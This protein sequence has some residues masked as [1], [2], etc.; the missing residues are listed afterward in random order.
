MGMTEWSVFNLEHLEKMKS[1]NKFG[2]QRKHK[3]NKTTNVDLSI[4]VS[5]LIIVASCHLFC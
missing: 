5:G 1:L 2:V 3:D 4:L